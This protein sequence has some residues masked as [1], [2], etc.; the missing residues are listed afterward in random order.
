MVRFCTGATAWKGTIGGI[1]DDFRISY[2][3]SYTRVDTQSQQTRSPVKVGHSRPGF[4]TFYGQLMEPE[5]LLQYCS[6]ET[7][8]GARVLLAGRWW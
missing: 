8:R 2:S 1:E 4:L 6:S 5:V 3:Q 7:V